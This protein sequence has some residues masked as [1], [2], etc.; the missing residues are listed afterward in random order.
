MR[1]SSIA[2][3][4]LA[5]LLYVGCEA[6]RASDTPPLASTTAAEP[7]MAKMQPTDVPGPRTRTDDYYWLRDRENPEVISYLEAENAYTEA[8]T[9]HLKAL[10]EALFEEI[11]GRIKEDDSS[12][13]YKEG[14]YFYYTRYEEDKEYPIYARKQGA[15]DA[16]EQIMLDANVLA[17]GHE[18]FAVRGREISA[19]QDILAY[20]VDTVGRR[21]YTLQFKNLTTGEVLPE[22]IPEVTGNVAWASDNQTIFYTKQDLTTLRWYQI[23][24]HVLGTD[25]VNDELVYEEKD[26]TFSSF[27]FRTKSKRYILIGS[28]QTLS[29]EYRYLDANDPSGTFQII[30]PREENHEYNVDHYGDHFFI[31][32]NDGAQNFRL[33]KTPVTATEKANWEEVIPHRAD[34]LLENFEMFKDYLVL[35]ERKDGLIR[36]R[37]RPWDGSGE[38][39]IAFGEPA[40]LAY[41]ETN[42]EF[43][44]PVLRYGYTSM[45][46]PNSVY[47]YHMATQD[48]TLMKQDEVLGDFDSARY[49]TERLYATARDGVQVPIS[50]VYRT[51]LFEQNG[52]APLLLYGYGSYGFSMDATFSSAR[53]SL[54]DRGFVYAIAHI[55]GGQEMGRQWYEDGKL[56]KKKN[57]FTDFID[58]GEYLVTEKYADPERLFAMGGSAGGL[59]VGAVINM[60]PDLFT[61]VVAAVP[62]VD[63]VTTMLDDAI[64][65]TTSEYDEWG[66]PNDSTYYDYMLSYSPYDNVAAKDY[67]NLLVTTGLH[68]SQVQYWEPAKWVARLRAMKTDQN[69]LLLKTNMDAGHGGASGRYKRYRETAFQ[70]A[71]LL[72][73]AGIQSVTP[74]DS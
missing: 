6:D 28:Q 33:V 55:R 29:S 69:R 24:R 15:L 53:L 47:D 23:Y 56:L 62:F 18:Y 64:P 45:T 40:Y 61:G 12:V 70:Y 4:V 30:Q 72:D 9:A 63:V 3:L 21:I 58:S 68:D 27:V 43:D 71:F 52:T 59:L 19:N 1:V 65:L 66:N 17:D 44:T 14:D 48:K 2:L 42:P 60:R 67:P 25:S 7:P 37:V 11:K 50:L 31:R 32:T 16:E 39:Y 41:V 51:D 13:P 22:E 57:T 46:T 73:L 10:E 35:S 54:L 49:T 26:D 20:S 74:A 36:L 34:V 8:E 38:H 5:S